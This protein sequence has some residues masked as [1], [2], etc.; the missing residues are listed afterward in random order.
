MRKKSATFRDIRAFPRSKQYRQIARIVCHKIHTYS[1]IEDDRCVSPA[2]CDN[3]PLFVERRRANWKKA[4]RDISSRLDLVTLAISTFVRASEFLGYIIRS[5]CG[6]AHIDTHEH[7]RALSCALARSLARLHAAYVVQACWTKLWP[8][9]IGRALRVVYRSTFWSCNTRPDTDRRGC[10]KR[11]ANQ[12]AQASHKLR[13]ACLAKLSA[14][15]P[16][17]FRAGK[18]PLISSA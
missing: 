12:S 4:R 6:A 11:A 7:V 14:G 2:P 3:S 15:R 8:V 10:A 16:F 9:S 13:S 1:L 18:K 5:F 17:M